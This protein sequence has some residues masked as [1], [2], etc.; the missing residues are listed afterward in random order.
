MESVLAGASPVML[1]R[2]GY[3]LE[4]RTVETKPG[5]QPTELFDETRQA[6]P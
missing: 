4:V 1:V 6:T 2:H 3:T 5:P